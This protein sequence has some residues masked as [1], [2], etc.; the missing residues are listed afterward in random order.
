MQTYSRRVRRAFSCVA[1]VGAFAG[2]TAVGCGQAAPSGG[3]EDPAG[4]GGDVASGASGNNT[5]AAGTS[6]N[7]AGSSVGGA[8]G[9][10]NGGG[11]SGAGVGGS[12]GSGTGGSAVAGVDAGRPVRTGPLRIMAMGDSITTSTCFRGKLAQLLDMKHKGDYDFVGTQ[13]GGC[14]SI[15]YDTDNEGHGGYL[16]TQHTSEFAG[17]ATANTIDVMLL[18]FATN[19]NW[20]SLAPAKILTAYTT[21][22]TEFRKH[23]PSA[24][25]LVAQLIPL[26]PTGCDPCQGNVKTFNAAIPAWAQMTT[27]AMS[28]V[29]VVDQWTGYDAIA[30]NRD[31]VHP[32]DD[33]GSVKMAKKW[34][35]A[36]E[37]LF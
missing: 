10:A 7:A 13:K 18:H 27:T 9:H 8:G 12:A 35:E 28:P 34:D 19:D 30:D 32:N 5:A 3:D 24:V 29:I 26:A 16:I 37:P 23:S 22:V 31:G 1:A 17:W 36:L 25:I 20:N 11:S 2:L 21:L 6:Q 15:K 4:G 33:G 14:D